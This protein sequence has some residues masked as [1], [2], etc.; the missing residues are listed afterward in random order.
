MGGNFMMGGSAN[1]MGGNSNM[2]SGVMNGGSAMGSNAMNKTAA[3]RPMAQKSDFDDDFG[4][5]SAAT[6]PA[7]APAS[8][9]NPVNKLI[10]L[11]G[12]SRNSD[13]KKDKLSEPI[14]ANQAA[15]TFVQEKEQ[16][17]QYVQQANKGS[18]MSFAGIDGLN[19]PSFGGLQP[20]MMTS[21]MA[22]T[23]SMGMNPNVMGFGGASAS[24]I[25]MLDP[26][27]MKSA[28][29]A[30]PQLG[31]QQGMMMNPQ[32]AMGGIGNGTTNAGMQSGM[33]GM[34]MQPSMG[35]MGMQPGMG[36]MGM[37]PGMG[38]MGMQP[39][40]GGMGMGGMQPAMGGMQPGMMNNQSMAFNPAMM[41]GSAMGMGGMQNG[42]MGN[43]G[44]M[45]SGM[46]QQQQGFR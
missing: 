40:M 46:D 41:G 22:P 1:V 42:S 19:K 9:G 13:K 28:S 30:Q 17:Q 44:G 38:G 32:M 36:G 45:P 35:G 27:A 10:S 5:F 2:M 43:F 31:M 15:A 14:I 11:D 39:G 24:T 16:I 4:D 25:G 12:L 3:S 23:M 18:S 20:A 33:G 34:G 37:Q 21:S 8:S 29:S 6:G 7:A 26:N